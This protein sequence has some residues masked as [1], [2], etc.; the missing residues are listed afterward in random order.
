MNDPKRNKQTNCIINIH[1]CFH[2]CI[3]LDDD[4]APSRVECVCRLKLTAKRAWTGKERIIKKSNVNTT[5]I[6]VTFSL[7]SRLLLLL[8]FRFHSLISHFVNTHMMD[9]RKLGHHNQ[10]KN[11]L[12]HSLCSENEAK[13][14]NRMRTVNKLIHRTILIDF[15]CILRTQKRQL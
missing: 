7:S 5:L 9:Q 15:F 2:I 14:S 8:F 6:D 13:K 4:T 1:E 10:I 12:L 3:E 11:Y